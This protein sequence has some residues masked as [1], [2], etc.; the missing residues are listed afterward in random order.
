[1]ARET[2]RIDVTHTPEL[3]RIAEEV[4]ASNEPYVLRRDSEDIAMVVPVRKRGAKRAISK[5]DYEAF[6]SSA[7]GWKGSV[8]VDKFLKDNE[9]SRR[10]SI[11]PPVKL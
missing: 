8:D 6:L 11:R 3:L 10:I 9:R 1:M 7:G 5:A 4:R 2:R